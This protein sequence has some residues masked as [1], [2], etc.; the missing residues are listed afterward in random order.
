MAVY[1]ILRAA[2]GYLLLGLIVRILGWLPGNDV[3]YATLQTKRIDRHHSQTLM[4][5]PWQ[6]AALRLKV[7][8]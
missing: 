7:L 3:D 5:A 6:P 2:F 8:P 1:F 4:R